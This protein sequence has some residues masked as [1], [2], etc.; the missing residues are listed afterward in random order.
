MVGVRR[1]LY[2]ASSTQMVKLQEGIHSTDSM[3]AHKSIGNDFGSA[4]IH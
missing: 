1:L 2:F 4:V 3:E